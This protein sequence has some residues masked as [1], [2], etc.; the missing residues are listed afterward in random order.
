M[1]PLQLV[2]RSLASV[3]S[4]YLLMVVGLLIYSFGWISCIMPANT[5][6]GGA[7]GFAL[8]LYHVTGLPIGALTLVINGVLLVVGGLVVG[9][10]FGLKTVF[11][12]VMLAVS[13]SI[14][15]PLMEG[16]IPAGQT[17]FGLDPVTDRILLVIMGGILAGAGVALCFRQGGSTG[18]TDIVAM[19]INKYKTISYGRILMTVDSMIIISSLFVGG[20]GVDSVIY[21]FV[22]T[23]VMGYTV[24]VIQSGS[25]QS[26]QIFVFTRRYAELSDV[27]ITHTHHSAT[28]LDATGWYSKE[29]IKIV[30]VVCRKRESAQMLNMVRQVDPDAFVSMGSVM[31]V[32]GKGFEA[33]NKI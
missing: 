28:V 13:M 9:W 15:Q 22:V 11:C 8:L 2:P 4:E 7:A 25:Q 24:D 19:I 16:L 6:S 29:G 27:I 14:V 26:S 17:V 5:L 18:G 10:N 23:A 33:L 32:Y 21:G 3:V 20:M 12:I 31:G 1:K 30:L